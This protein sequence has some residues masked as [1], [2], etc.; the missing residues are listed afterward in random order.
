MRNGTL[1]QLID[2]IVPRRCAGCAHPGTHWCRTC[3]TTLTGLFAVERSATY[4]S[5]P[6]YA[7]TTYSGPARKAVIAYKERGRRALAVPLGNALTRALPALAA[8]APAL[9]RVFWVPTVDSSS[10]ADVPPHAANK[11]PGLWLV[12]APSSKAAA[13]RRGGHHMA[14]VAAVVADNLTGSGLV[15]GT[16]QALG[17]A[18]RAKDSVGLGPAERAANLARHLVVAPTGLPPPG[19][20]LLVLDDVVTTGATAA[21]CA[22]ALGTAGYPV[23]AVLVCAATV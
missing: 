9:A 19:T 21:A 16:T 12:P 2:L 3:D 5:P 15:A 17:F 22:R 14:R 7:L 6:V 20:P 23:L 13:R 10:T 11:P 1:A 4:R 8:R 18:S